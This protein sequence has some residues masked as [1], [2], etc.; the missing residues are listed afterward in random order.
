MRIR[1]LIKIAVVLGGVAALVG[2]ILVFR[3]HLGAQSAL[4]IVRAVFFAVL[5][6]SG[7]IGWCW[8]FQSRAKSI[9]RKWAAEHGYAVLHFDSPFHTGAFSWRNTSRGQ[10]I[11]SVGI[12]DDA[13]RERKA[14]VRC[15]SYT[16]SV[17][18]SDEIEVKWQDEPGAA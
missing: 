17:L 15:G 8:V 1:S 18:F 12:R 13:G 5:A 2:L 11:Y 9:V 6:I 10:V 7:F 4:A 3:W 16:G 14:W